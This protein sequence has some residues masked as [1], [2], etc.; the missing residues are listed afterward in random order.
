MNEIEELIL[1]NLTIVAYCLGSL[2]IFYIAN[3]CF[4]LWYNISGLGQQFDKEKI[5]KSLLKL[6]VFCIGLALLSIGITL[7]PIIL[8]YAKIDMTEEVKELATQLSIT[9]VIMTVAV[10][11]LVE[12]LGKLKKILNSEFEV[13]DNAEIDNAIQEPDDALRLQKPRV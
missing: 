4:S 7:L 12:A 3:I 11:Y 8:S 10:K 13:E 1:H 9:V 5:I 6:L 2:A